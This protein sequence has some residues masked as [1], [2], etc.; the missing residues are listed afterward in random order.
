MTPLEVGALIV[1][2][3]WLAVLSFIVLLLVRQ[4]GLIAVGLS[5]GQSQPE[6]GLPVGNPVPGDVKGSL[7]TL[8]RDLAYLLFVSPRCSSCAALLEEMTTRIF[9]A[10]EVYAIMPGVD[11]Q[12]DFRKRVPASFL[13]VIDPDATAIGRSLKVRSTPYALQVENGIV[14]GKAVIQD[15]DDLERLIVAHEYSD[16]A[17][18]A[19]NL[20]EVLDSAG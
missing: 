8:D 15:A 6:D 7:P 11:E 20:R 12:H 18:M 3:I 1:V 14:T 9:P 4:L 19:R 16:A 17:E 13:Q 10:S 5:E 2:S